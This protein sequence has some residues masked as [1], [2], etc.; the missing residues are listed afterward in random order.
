MQKLQ[1][2]YKILYRILI[3]NILFLMSLVFVFLK[4]NKQN[5]LLINYN[6]TD[7]DYYTSIL[8]PQQKS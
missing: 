6:I 4:Y 3:P 8:N 5:R 1:K 7:N 2:L